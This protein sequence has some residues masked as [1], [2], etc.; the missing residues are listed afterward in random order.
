MNEDYKK[1][2]SGQKKEEKQNDFSNENIN[3]KQSKEIVS[4]EIKNNKKAEKLS[5]DCILVDHVDSI[6]RSTSKI[7]S[8][9]RNIITNILF[10]VIILL[11]VFIIWRELSKEVI[12]FE[13]INVPEDIKKEHGYTGR[14][15]TYEVI[16]K[17]NQINLIAKTT[18][19]RIETIPTWLD[20]QQDIKVPGL[21][22]SVNSFFQFFRN[23][24]GIKV[25]RIAGEISTNNNQYYLTTR[26]KSSGISR[27]P[28]KRIPINMKY[29]DIALRKA[30][31]YICKHTDPFI[32]AS[33]FY[34]ID[35]KLSIKVIKD[36]LSNEL[37][38]DEMYSRA[39]NLWGI[40]LCEQGK[41]KEA[42]NKYEIA[43]KLDPNS[44]YPYHN[45]G[46]TLYKSGDYNGAISKYNI[47]IEKDR[48]LIPAHI[49]LSLTW[50]FNFK[51]KSRDAFNKIE[52]IIRLNKRK[53]YAGYAYN[54]R[55]TYYG[56]YGTENRKYEKAIKDF[57]R[58]IDLNPKFISPYLNLCETQII[59]SEGN[60]K[61]EDSISYIN[62]ALSAFPSLNEAVILLYFQSI[63]EKINDIDTK[64]TDEMLKRIIENCSSDFFKYSFNELQTI[65]G[66]CEAIVNDNIN[67]PFKETNNIDVLNELIQDTKL[68][69]RL[70]QKKK[71]ETYS[72]DVML[73]LKK[74]KK[75]FKKD[76]SDLNDKEK[77]EIKRLNRLILE[78]IY[79]R[80][81][82]KSKKKIIINYNFGL[83]D[84]WLEKLEKLKFPKNKIHF[85]KDKT[86][87]LKQLLRP[88]IHSV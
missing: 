56:L 66:L 68:Y 74:T 16:D 64:E 25:T 50:L 43:V 57:K 54:A 58:A 76:Y 69:D 5:I 24:L 86:K 41:Y 81:T 55:G 6:G 49:N 53:E 29:L 75:Y 61:I 83:I 11:F 13:P 20:T 3:E 4:N 9:I 63:I 8:N 70:Y 18:A 87:E 38:E 27:T 22:F 71:V 17:I 79:P 51:S 88:P 44:G 60:V 21:G 82:P 45:W 59:E 84:K 34:E 72:N 65:E 78:E 10:L 35:T 48:N 67:L 2:G 36:I 14:V 15:I 73:L 39:Y 40:I 26:I 37:N 52:N 33:Y 85:I 19:E 42:I 31:E 80:E 46:R 32:L 28:A 1:A 12:L 62:E 7:T 30:A 47:A 77:K 23:I